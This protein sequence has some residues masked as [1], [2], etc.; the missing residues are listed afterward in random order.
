MIDRCYPLPGGGHVRAGQPPTP[1]L[2]SA[3]EELADAVRRLPMD[4]EMA[5]RQKAGRERI[6]ERNARLQQT[7][8]PLDG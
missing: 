8:V 3:L 6:R 2:V 4:P 7:R 5:A 1:E